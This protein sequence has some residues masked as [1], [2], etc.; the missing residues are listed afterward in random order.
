MFYSYKGKGWHR[1]L[2]MTETPELLTKT[3]QVIN[4][5]VMFIVVECLKTTMIMD[6]LSDVLRTVRLTGSIFFTADLN[7][8]WS[9]SSPG[10]EVILQQSSEKS[11]VSYL[12]SYYYRRKLLVS[13]RR[14]EAFFAPKRKCDYISA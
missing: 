12:I 7:D 11:R 5:L 3:P 4:L 6:V 10:S 2:S 13:T 8:P 14:N 1:P 9:I